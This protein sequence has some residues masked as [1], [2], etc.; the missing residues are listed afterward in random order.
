MLFAINF[1]PLALAGAP[2]LEVPFVCP[3]PA[4][5][6][7]QIG[8]SIQYAELMTYFLFSRPRFLRAREKPAD[9]RG[10]QRAKIAALYQRFIN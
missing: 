8:K 6:A 5:S 2:L 7:C 3:T 1:F 10:F 9:W 4:Q